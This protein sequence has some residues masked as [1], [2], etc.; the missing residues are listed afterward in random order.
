MIWAIAAGLAIAAGAAWG[1]LALW[2]QPLM[3]TRRQPLL[4]A[5]WLALA[6][7][8][9]IGLATGHAWPAWL[10]GALL[11]ALLAWWLSLIHI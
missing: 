7:A 9:L 5:A 8:A 4:P 2:F 11:V 3:G 1:A 10:F 6:A